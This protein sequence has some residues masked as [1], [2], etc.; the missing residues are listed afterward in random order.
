MM[1]ERN[2]NKKDAVIS[3][4]KIQN[5]PLKI[6]KP[7]KENVLHPTLRDCPPKV[8]KN[9]IAET[10]SIATDLPTIETNKISNDY[11]KKILANELSKAPE[12][13][14]TDF[15]LRHKFGSEIRARMVN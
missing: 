11:L 15:L 9:H 4:T 3:Q 13:F 5:S 7:S 1:I 2:E 12:N 8:S 6:P 10:N 14:R